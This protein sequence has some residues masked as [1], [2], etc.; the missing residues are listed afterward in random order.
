M[1]VDRGGLTRAEEVLAVLHLLRHRRTAA[2]GARDGRLPQE[3]GLQDVPKV[4]GQ[5]LQL[6]QRATVHQ[7]GVS[8]E[9]DLGKGC[10]ERY[11]SPLVCP[12]I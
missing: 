1:E 6:T 4:Q 9:E 5:V 7:A 8:M 12:R 11:Q 3:A 2:T 10:G